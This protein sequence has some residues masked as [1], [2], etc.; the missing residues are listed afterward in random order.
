MLISIVSCTIA[1]DSETGTGNHIK[2]LDKEIRLGMAE[3]TSTA[4]LVN[5]VLDLYFTGQNSNCVW[6]H[7]T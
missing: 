3:A 4:H 6:N 7:E 2:T 5:N 1:A